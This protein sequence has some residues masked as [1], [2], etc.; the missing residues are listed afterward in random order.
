[1][2]TSI[3]KGG[4]GVKWCDTAFEDTILPEIQ[5][6]VK[7]DRE[8]EDRRIE[9]E[10][11][12]SRVIFIVDENPRMFSEYKTKIT[13]TS[14]PII[15]LPDSS[16]TREDY[17]AT[18]GDRLPGSLMS[19]WHMEGDSL[20]PILISVAASLG[21]APPRC[22]SKATLERVQ[23]GFENM[24]SEELNVLR[25]L[26]WK[27]ILRYHSADPMDEDTE[28]EESEDGEEE[29]QTSGST[30]ES[31]T[32]GTSRES[33]QAD[34]DQADYGL[35]QP[36]TYTARSARGHQSGATIS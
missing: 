12:A 36:K 13:Q 17:L 15:E 32:S 27:E 23:E 33:Q 29:G 30:A 14:T 31:Q 2:R 22:T 11:K 8:F 7:W 6:A 34:D 19:S 4:E 9:R 18:S 5:R 25:G 16:P 20:G 10:S 24:I 35:K 26:H 3:T 28:I 21:V 1:M